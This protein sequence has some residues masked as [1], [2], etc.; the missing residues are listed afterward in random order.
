[1]TNRREFIKQTSI[2]IASILA[3]RSEIFA[4]DP[5]MK[6][7]I[8][9]YFSDAE[10][11]KRMIAGCQKDDIVILN[12]NNGP[13]IPWQ[14]NDEKGEKIDAKIKNYQDQIKNAIDQKIIIAG[15][16]HSYWQINS[17]THPQKRQFCGI[18]EEIDTY[19]NIY[20]IKDIFFD[21]FSLDI[22]ES[23][24]DPIKTLAYYKEFCDY[25]HQQ[26]GITILNPGSVI[27]EKFAAIAK[28]IVV[29]ENSFENYKVNEKDEKA[30]K[31]SWSWT[32]EAKREQIAHLVYSANDKK[33]M[34]LAI[35]KAK[36]RNV[37]YLYIND[38]DSWSKL[39]NYWK[40]EVTE[41]RS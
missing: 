19:K 35:D 13:F 18:K 10:L 40:E 34:K 8:P 7:I 11:W 27:S 4:A 30:E 33:Q 21:E 6:F 2:G 36:T 1:M 23:D 32:L 20:G 9:A 22:G 16:V 38:T 5:K 3:L 29:F 14:A 26:G 12:P 39:P 28:K 31:D 15:Y 24:K 37:G 17:K 41:I 25:V